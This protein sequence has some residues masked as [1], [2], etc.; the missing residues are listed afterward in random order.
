MPELKCLMSHKVFVLKQ[1]S[2]LIEPC[3][4]LAVMK[5]AFL[6]GIS[7]VCAC[8]SASGFAILSFLLLTRSLAPPTAYFEK[9][10]YFD[11]TKPA[12]VASANFCKSP[13]LS[14]VSNAQQAANPCLYVRSR[15]MSMLYS[16]ITLLEK[17]GEGNAAGVYGECQ[18]SATRADSQFVAGAR[19]P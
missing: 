10:L 16:H 4:G 5:T 9:E 3:C 12:A 6:L 19:D 2:F 17:Q 1:C 8:I 11:Y 14:K 7:L 15:C 13:A 18:I